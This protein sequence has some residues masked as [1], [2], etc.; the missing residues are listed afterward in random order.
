MRILRLMTV[1]LVIAALLAVPRAAGARASDQP[2]FAMPEQAVLALIEAVTASDLPRLIA[3][4]GPGSDDLASTSDPEAGRRNREVFAVAITEGWKLVDR[5]PKGKILVVGNEDWPFPVPLVDGPGGWRFDT[6]AGREEVI[7]RRIG[8]NELGAIKVCQTY[9]VAQRI[10]ASRSHDGKSAG[11]YARRVR[12]SPGTQ[13]GLYWPVVRGGP[14]SPLGELAADAAYEKA[15]P[16]PSSGGVPFHGYYYR[17]LQSQGPAAPGGAVEYVINGEMSRGFAL[18]AFP[19]QYDV[20]GVMTF[21]VNRDGVV[22]E[23]D[24][25]ASTSATA[26]TMTRFNPDPTWQ[27]V[28]VEEEP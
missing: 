10:Y 12:S 17:T 1:A 23:K 28:S 24:L 22:Y 14:R 26:S 20:T 27:K 3:L 2:V 9:V 13:D 21:I 7:D 18:V 5:L 25:G 4:M 8:R 15:G 11:V 16:T 6:A 19:A